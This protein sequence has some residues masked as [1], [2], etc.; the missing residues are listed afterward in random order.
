MCLISLPSSHNM[1]KSC[2]TLSNAFSPVVLDE[3]T[4]ESNKQLIRRTLKFNLGCLF[5]FRVRLLNSSSSSSLPFTSILEHRPPQA[6]SILL[7]LLL[8]PSIFVPRVSSGHP[9]ISSVAYPWGVCFPRV[10]SGLFVC[11][12]CYPVVSHY[13]LQIATSALPPPF[14]H[15]LPLFWRGSIRFSSC[16]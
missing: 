1:E 10:S 14:L 12:I 16:R 11:S 8:V 4:R 7:Y 3:Q 5:A 6:S 13:A 2:L 15:L 9:P